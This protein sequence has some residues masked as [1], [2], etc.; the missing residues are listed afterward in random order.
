MFMQKAGRKLREMRYAYDAD[1]YSTA[2]ATILS[3]HITAGGVTALAWCEEPDGAAVRRVRGDGRLSL[4][5][6]PDQRVR[7]ARHSVGG[8]VVESIAA[9]PN[10]DGTADELW[11]I[12]RRTI[13]GTTRRYIEF[14]EAQ[15]S[16]HHVDAGLL[17]D[18]ARPRAPSRPWTIWKARL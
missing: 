9:I 5:F 3:E 13:G 17:Y 6:E 15:D 12:A 18:G 16:G 1:A 14:I 2:D 10:P 7:L 8:A 11:L 4:T